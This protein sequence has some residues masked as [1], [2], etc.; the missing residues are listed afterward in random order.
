MARSIDIATCSFGIRYFF[1]RS[2]SLCLLMLRRSTKIYATSSWS[3]TSVVRNYVALSFNS[4]PVAP[5]KELNSRINHSTDHDATNP[6]PPPPT[7][8]TPSSHIGHVQPDIDAAPKHPSEVTTASFELVNAGPGAV[9]LAHL[10]PRTTVRL[11][12][13]IVVGHSP[14]VIFKRPLYGGVSSAVM[15]RLVGDPLFMDE[16]QADGSAADLL[17]APP[18]LGDLALL[19]LDGSVDLGA[20]R[21]AV[22]AYTGKITTRLSTTGFGWRID[23]LLNRQITGRGQLVLNAYGGIYRLGLAPGEVYYIEPRRIVAWDLSLDSIVSLP[24]NSDYSLPSSMTS[25]ER[26]VRIEGP[27][28]IYLAS[29]VEPRFPTLKSWLFENDPYRQ[30]SERIPAT[31]TIKSNKIIKT[32]T[33]ST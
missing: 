7:K 2:S 25:N 18:R 3:P 26:L 10:P 12:P 14:N 27:G 23:G 24:P 32:K 21:G 30:V 8:T 33:E 31:D 15:G 19:S 17:L 5:P 13:G 11:S 16:Y 4:Q 22:V 1:L 6:A 9:M 29:R 20:R 28:D